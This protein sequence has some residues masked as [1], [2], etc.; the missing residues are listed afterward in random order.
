MQSS[1]SSL[2]KRARQELRLD[3][4]H[5]YVFMLDNDSLGV[6]LYRN[7]RPYKLDN[8]LVPRQVHYKKKMCKVCQD[9]QKFKTQVAMITWKVMMPR[10]YINHQLYCVNMIGT[11]GGIQMT[12]SINLPI[13]S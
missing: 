1:S 13:T 11:E 5:Y 12:I 8:S 9:M 3:M 7:C 6:Q 10:K 4:L 2:I